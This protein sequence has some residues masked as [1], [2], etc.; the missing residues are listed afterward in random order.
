MVDFFQCIIK[1]EM[2]TDHTIILIT[3]VSST[4]HKKIHLS[5]FMERHKFFIKLT[6][7]SKVM[8]NTIPVASLI[9]NPEVKPMNL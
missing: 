6:L 1:N 9:I 4:S 3:N 2:E 7:T 8:M 5:V